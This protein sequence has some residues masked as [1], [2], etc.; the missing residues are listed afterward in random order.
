MA[1]TY[2]F[3]NSLNGDR[4]YD[5]LQMSR[6]FEG[7]IT[8]G[9]FMSLGDG[10]VVRTNTGMSIVVG[11]GKAWFNN[12]WTSNDSD[13]ILT[14]D[15]SELV[16]NRID[17]V[18]IEV[19]SQEVSRANSIKI[20][21]GTP[22]STPVAPTLT[23]AGGI[24]QYPLADVYIGANVITIATIDIT[25]RIG[26]E[27]TPFITGIL[28]A[29]DFTTLLTQF[30]GQFDVWFD[31]MKDQL[32]TDAAGNLQ[33]QIN[34]ME[35]AYLAA[36]A[37][38]V[39]DLNELLARPNDGWNV[40]TG[41]CT[42][43]SADS[44]TG[45][46]SVAAN[47]LDHLGKGM[48]FKYKQLQDLSAYFSFNTNSTPDLGV[49]TPTDSNM[50]YAAGKFGNA[51]VFNG[52]N[53]LISIADAALLKPTADFTIGLWFKTN[54]A[55][56]D[57]MLFQS[58]SANAN[59][60]GFSLYVGLDNRLCFR[61]GNN[62]GASALSSIFSIINPTD[63]NWHYVVCT[64]RNNYGQMYLD[65]TLEASG[66]MYAPVYA[67]TNYVRIGCGNQTGANNIF[68][69]GQIDDLFLI[70]G[71]ALDEETI[72]AKY[73]DAT[74]QG[75]SAIPVIKKAIITD[76]QL[77]TPTTTLVTL[78]HGTDHM[79]ANSAITLPHYSHVKTPAGFNMNPDKW[80]VQY[81]TDTDLTQTSPASGTAYNIGGI[82]LSFPIGVW[83]TLVQ[84]MIIANAT[85][86]SVMPSLSTSFG[87]STLNNGYGQTTLRSNLRSGLP[88]MTNGNLGEKFIIKHV[89]TTGVKTVYYILVAQANTTSA[90]I[91]SI[92]VQN[93]VFRL[94]FKITSAYL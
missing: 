48:R 75:V 82:T 51:A 43:Q 36:D 6:L 65:G 23:N 34:A 37:A 40:E 8:D 26:M 17:T 10:L 85:F 3:Y 12:T 52:T 45:V 62:T 67:V 19:N 39:E 22:G 46:I 31:A 84:A 83:D 87:I 38:I 71:Y 89:V 29:I 32:S 15:I 64:Y 72:K 7:I 69:N 16:L 47:A 58:Y 56:T 2:G 93:S 28:E 59:I 60:A 27:D 24:Y 86:A 4:K 90:A 53:A 54:I 5:A 11:S 35:D 80:S 66:Y 21:K 25:N 79:L 94:I 57:K 49:L 9:I 76:V 68:F 42:Y 70:N 92:L 44:P 41:E 14:H 77:T 63:G 74:A 20:V 13:L 18:V 81:Y 78:Y 61:I 33:N 50:S 55:G 1:V 91:T 30:E 88:I 73:L